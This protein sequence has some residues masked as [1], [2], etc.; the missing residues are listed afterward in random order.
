MRSSRT[1]K[2]PTRP[3]DYRNALV[4]DLPNDS[5]VTE[6]YRILRTNLLLS[7]GDALR[8]IVVTSATTAEGKSITC[9]NLG[10]VLSK[11]D[12]R[13]VIVDADLRRAGQ[14]RIFGVAAGN[15]A[16]LLE[17]SSSENP[18]LTE[19]QIKE[20]V[21]NVGERLDLIPAGGAVSNPA[22]VIG[23]THFDQFLKRLAKMYDVVLVDSPPVGLLTDAAVLATRVDGTIFV[24]DY[25]HTPRRSAQRAVRALENVNANIVGVVVNRTPA[26]RDMST[27]AG[28][29]DSQP[30][31]P[32]GN[33]PH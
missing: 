13:V 26:K 22:E 19:T 10:V 5:A 20:I 29:Y 8:S 16:S 11:S 33:T 25:Q 32:N 28:Y 30:V 9:A 17:Q 18:L 12:K 27:N 6:S 1:A 7:A 31:Q 4:R 21:I 14:H 3:A 2:R 15:Y 23:S 24:L